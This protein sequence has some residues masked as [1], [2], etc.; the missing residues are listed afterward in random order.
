MRYSF[1]TFFFHGGA[2]GASQYHWL[3]EVRNRAI[4]AKFLFATADS[5]FP[6]Y[7]HFACR[8]FLHFCRTRVTL[9]MASK[10]IRFSR[11]RGNNYVSARH[12]WQSI[13]WNNSTLALDGER[14]LARKLAEHEN[15]TSTIVRGD[16]R[17]ELV[18]LKYHLPILYWSFLLSR[19]IVKTTK[20]RAFLEKYKWYHFVPVKRIRSRFE[21]L[22]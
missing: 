6:S 21:Q 5:I 20:Y 19:N 14:L 2:S 7:F 3:P 16:R 18:P 4:G 9:P 11:S 1:P 13:P 15:E 12:N 8:L 10:L 17:N 22:L